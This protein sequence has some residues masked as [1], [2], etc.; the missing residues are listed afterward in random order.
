M[1]HSCANGVL[2]VTMSVIGQKRT[3]MPHVRLLFIATLLVAGSVG[4]EPIWFVLTGDPHNARTDVA[5]V[6][7]AGVKP[8]GVV[9]VLEFRVT[10]A[11]QRTMASGEAYT[12]YVS[13]VKVDCSRSAVYHL[14]QTR[15]VDPRWQGAATF[16]EF[17]QTKPMAFGG[18]LPTPRPVLL[19][20]VCSN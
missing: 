4:A 13:H 8:R 15:Y 1:T 19:K 11:R 16:E 2:I 6:N 3:P 17:S 18:F 12:S 9:Q 20:A 14:D 10:L 5:E 7:L